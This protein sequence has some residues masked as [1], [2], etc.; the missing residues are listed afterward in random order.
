[1]AGR[2]QQSTTD[3]IIPM[4]VAFGQIFNFTVDLVEN[5]TQLIDGFLGAFDPNAVNGP[6][7]KREVLNPSLLHVF[8]DPIH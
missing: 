2:A 1:M 4:H 3:P 5:L 6:R 7:T 8:R